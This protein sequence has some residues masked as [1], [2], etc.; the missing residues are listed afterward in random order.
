[1]ETVK[2]NRKFEEAIN[3][4]VFFKGDEWFYF[5]GVRFPRVNSLMRGS[6]A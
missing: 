4:S 2:E 5:K 1:M 6:A 3:V